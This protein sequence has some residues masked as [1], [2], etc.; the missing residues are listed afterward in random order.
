MAAPNRGDLVWLDF[1]PQAG[2]EQAGRRPAIVLSPRSYHQKTDY[3]IVCPITSNVTAYPFAVPLPDG[4]PISGAVLAD[5]VK[6]LDRRVRRIEYAGQA[7]AS[8][9]AEVVAR[10][11]PLLVS[12]GIGQA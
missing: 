9:L 12:A 8:V 5:Q 3:V 7:P 6:S 11:L 10:L 1:N 2:R 4:L